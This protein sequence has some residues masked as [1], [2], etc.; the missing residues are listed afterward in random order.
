V[1]LFDV[2]TV[3]L[4]R[5]LAGAALRHEVLSANIANANTPGYHRAD[6]DFHSALARALSGAATP[7]SVEAV[8][9][10]AETDRSGP[11]RYDGSSVDPEREMASLAENSL[12]YQAIVATLRARMRMLETAIGGRV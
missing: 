3:A 7:Q 5:A 6:V 4:E 12:E 10:A 1:E 2:T 9:F 8:K 11:V